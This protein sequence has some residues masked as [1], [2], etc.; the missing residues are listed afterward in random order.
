M[1]NSCPVK[2]AKP[3]LLALLIVV[4]VL[5]G[6]LYF[7][8]HRLMSSGVAQTSGTITVP[9][10][11]NEV[12]VL[13]DRYGVPHIFADDEE[14]V[15]FAMGY[16]HAQDR[17]WNMDLIRRAAEG[18]LTEIFGDREQKSPAAEW[19]TTLQQDVFHRVIGF[20]DIGKQTARTS[21]GPAKIYLQR[22]ADGVNEWLKQNQN[23][24]PPEFTIFSFRPAPWEIA[25]TIALARYIAWGL[26]ANLEGELMRYEAICRFGVERGWEFF[27]RQGDPHGPYIVP[28]S[29]KKYDPR[30]KITDPDYLPLPPELVSPEIFQTL[31]D[32]ISPDV[33][34]QPRIRP[35]A[36]NNW[37][38][39][40]SRS[41]S[42]APILCNDPHLP[43][44]LPSVFYQA[45]L[46]TKD[47]LDVIGV[48]FP[49]IPFVVLGHNRRLAWA[50]T[51]TRAD[52]QDIFVEKTDPDHPGQYF[53][54]D[55][56]ENFKTRKEIIYVKTKNGKEAKE[57]TVRSSRHGPI[58]ND[59]LP[60]IPSKM[61]PVALRW[62]GFDQ[63]YDHIAFMG[64]A[65][66]GN[67]S[68]FRDA[69]MHMG[70]PIQNWVYADV[71]GNIGF[72]PCGRIPRRKK[73][74]G[75]LPVPGWTD[76]YEWVG[77]IPP[78]EIPQLLNPQQGYIVT[79]NNKVIPEEDYPYTIGYRYALYR[80]QRIEE[81]VTSKPKLTVE[82]MKKFQMDNYMIQGRRLV[83]FYLNACEKYCD[84]KDALLAQAVE[85]LRRW[86]FHTDTKNVG[87]AVFHRAY[88]ETMRRT[89]GDEI[90]EAMMNYLTKYTRA[91]SSLDDAVEN[92]DVYSFFDDARTQQAETRDQILA[93]ALKDAVEFLAK[94]YGGDVKK[95]QWGK[96]H[97]LE[98]KHPFS[99]VFPLSLLF[100]KLIVPLAGGRDTVD[101]EYFAWNDDV[102][103]AFA[104]PALRHIV[105]MAHVDDAV[106]VIDSGQA[107]HPRSKHFL[108][109]S[110]M[111]RDGKYIPMWMDEKSIRKNLEGELILQPV[112]KR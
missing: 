103:S 104:G 39:A 66:A 78:D 105:D 18:R 43:H 71:D 70:T 76:E 106:M 46:K 77:Y 88:Y 96:M 99:G 94:K 45:H 87:A 37:A 57:I 5:L 102:L 75:T 16:V 8:V 21:S 22:Y 111:W 58:L 55:H 84:K 109:Q 9:G 101:S 61:P 52:T 89:Y 67:A 33:A 107:G 47:G 90:S 20:W 110:H 40:G 29:Q 53:Y 64:F 80:A 60:D 19:G 10:L 95:W 82:D 79:A 63:S 7:I 23:N 83:G 35:F 24:L 108:D 27:P 81:L 26:S 34:F 56:W 49:G 1:R 38:V 85:Q 112:V 86:D 2:R 17:M 72:F 13:R 15:Y 32:A 91:E 42:G 12:R 65:R 62:T 25:D 74:D 51:T 98:L 31:L 59:V 14:D 4:I 100:G 68:E 28:P 92:G 93:A 97:K 36:S 69:L 73:G 3:F 41:A 30:G 54:I 6:V 48:T 44:L 11:K 50:A